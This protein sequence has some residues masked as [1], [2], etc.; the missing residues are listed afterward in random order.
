MANVAFALLINHLCLLVVYWRLT[1]PVIRYII[2]F[3]MFQCFGPTAK[4]LLVC[5]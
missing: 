2:G 5:K 1:Q 3:Q 4:L